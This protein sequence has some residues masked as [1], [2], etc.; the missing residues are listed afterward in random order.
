MHMKKNKEER[1]VC[2]M[3][4]EVCKQ[5]PGVCSKCNLHLVPE[6]IEKELGT[7]QPTEKRKV[8]QS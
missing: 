2:W 8:A 7:I 5:G 1:Y 6:E 3:H 4:L